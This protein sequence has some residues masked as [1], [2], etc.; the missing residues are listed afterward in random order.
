[1][2][3][4][5]QISMK[6]SFLWMI[7]GVVF[8]TL[9]GYSS[10][11]GLS[12]RQL[13]VHSNSLPFTEIIPIDSAS[14]EKGRHIADT[15]G[16]TGC[17]GN[18][19]EGRD[20]SEEWPDV[21]TPVAPNLAKYVR[22]HDP[23]VTE[24][25]IRKGIGQN[26]K[27]LFTMPSLSFATLSTTDVASLIGFF[28]S[29]PVVEKELPDPALNIRSRWALIRGAELDMV[30]KVG[31]LPKLLSLDAGTPLARGQYLAMTTCIECH[32]SD[33]RGAS[34]GPPDLSIV[35]AYSKSGFNR[36]LKEGIGLG[37]REDLGLMTEVA[38]G[39]FMHFS[40]M[41]V[42]DLY[43]FLQ[44]LKDYPIAEDVYWRAQNP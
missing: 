18:Q 34:W 28:Q 7:G 21:G 16:C 43:L 1:M 42:E 12:E 14:I 22:E 26:G 35:S 4:K 10:I 23:S 5:I 15:R 9:L 32:G 25:A 37:D 41:E 30:S 39:Q 3:P 40:E 29:M 33:L 2:C 44:T 8:L 6:L 27:A 19:L 24:A 20:L 11:Y 31:A 38:R 36:L 13:T 17:H